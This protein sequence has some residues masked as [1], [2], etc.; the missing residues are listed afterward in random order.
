MITRKGYHEYLVTE[1]EIEIFF[2]NESIGVVS[3]DDIRTCIRDAGQIDN[4]LID[5][6]FEE[7]AEIVL[8]L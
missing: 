1:K 3:I 5:A 4:R 6:Y 2:K 8:N 7:L